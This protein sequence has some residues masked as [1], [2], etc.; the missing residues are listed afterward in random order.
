MKI[1]ITCNIEKPLNEFNNRKKG[2]KD[3]KNN[4]CKECCREYSR[5]HYKNNK[6]QYFKKNLKFKNKRKNIFN[7]LK[8]KLK[9]SIC[10][11]ERYWVLDF[12]HLN[13][14]EKDF[15]LSGKYLTYS[16][17]K[18]LKEL[19]KCIV[20]CSNCHRDLHYKESE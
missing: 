3:G 16:K 15:E 10:G 19:N 13:K 20:L 8:S 17:E 18:L 14:N 5:N 6:I 7:D 1:C 11:E 2:S 12:H 4:K 9:C